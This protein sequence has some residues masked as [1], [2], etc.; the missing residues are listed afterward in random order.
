[1][2]KRRKRNHSFQED[3]M[4]LMTMRTKDPNDFDSQEMMKKRKGTIISAMNMPMIM[5]T[6]ITDNRLKIDIINNCIV[7]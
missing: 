1:M 5:T 4:G 2:N 3:S 7:I 6:L